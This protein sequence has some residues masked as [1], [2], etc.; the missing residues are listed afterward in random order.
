MDNLI[1]AMPKNNITL[2]TK[3]I[4]LMEGLL[5]IQNL[6]VFITMQNSGVAFSVYKIKKLSH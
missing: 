4:F 2:I 1:E 6:K 5:Q 3:E